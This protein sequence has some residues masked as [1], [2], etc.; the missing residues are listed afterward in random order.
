MVTK[1]SF[2]GRRPGA[3]AMHALACLLASARGVQCAS[4]QTSN[5]TRTCMTRDY[6]LSNGCSGTTVT[7]QG[8]FESTA[9]RARCTDQ[10]GKTVENEIS[11]DFCHKKFEEVRGRAACRDLPAA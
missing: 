11:Y 1:M 9:E 4:S 5:A 8:C 3:A 2:R 7:V 10:L 6:L